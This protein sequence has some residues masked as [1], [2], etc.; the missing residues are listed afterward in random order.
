VIFDLPAG[1]FWLDIQVSR[2]D[3]S[4]AKISCDALEQWLAALAWAGCCCSFAQLGADGEAVAPRQLLLVAARA[5]S[6]HLLFGI[7]EVAERNALV[8]LHLCPLSD[9]ASQTPAD[10]PVIWLVHIL[11]RCCFGC[12]LTGAQ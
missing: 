5:L 9:W 2:L 8:A 1:E 6:Q 11:V 4:Q 10:A 3:C 12:I 7:F